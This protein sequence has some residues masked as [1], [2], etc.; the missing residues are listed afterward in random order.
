MRVFTVFAVIISGCLLLSQRAM[1]QASSPSP[2]P[3]GQVGQYSPTGKSLFDYLTAG[4]KLV[5]VVLST[6]E[7]DSD[8]LYYLQ[9]GPSLALC[10]DSVVG[11][12][13]HFFI[14][15]ELYDSNTAPDAPPVGQ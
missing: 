1:A 13:N 9:K 3:N 10:D 11:S 5:S 15:S 8:F 14:C 6:S 12:Q 4:Y 7:N 2:H